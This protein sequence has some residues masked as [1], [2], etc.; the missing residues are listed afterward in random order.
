MVA[1]ADAWFSRNRSRLEA[2]SR[3]ARP[4]HPAN[5]RAPPRRVAARVL[6]I[7]CGQGTN[8]AA[9]RRAGAVDAHGIEPSAAAVEAGRALHPRHRL[10]CGTAGRAALRRTHS[11]DVVWFG[12]CLY[13]VDRVAAAA[14]DRR[15]RSRAARRRLPGHPR[16][17]SRRR[18]AAVPITTAPACGRT[19]WTTRASSWPTPPTGSSRRPAYRTTARAGIDDPQERVGPVDAA[20]GLRRTPTATLR[21]RHENLQR[22][23]R[24]AG[25]AEKRHPARQPDLQQEPHAV[26]ARRLALFHRRVPRA[27]ASGTWTATSTST[28]SAASPRSRWATA[29]R[30]STRA[31]RDAARRRASIFSL[32]HPLEAEVAELICDMVPCA[33]MVRFGKNGSDATS[34]AIRLARAFTGRDHVAVCG[35]HG[36]QD[37]YIG[38]HRAQPRRAA[39]DPRR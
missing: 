33:E 3:V 28:S 20:Q 10:R 4:G 9:L 8:L 27:R 38:S 34:G 29:T 12:F 35:Y 21:H 36:W 11:F 23:P 6:E 37:W 25:R 5:R 24:G 18:R 31:V 1:K 22:S 14:L 17:R 39:G 32:P 19:R 15:G 16:L 30:T 26:P 7:G 2:P 13:L